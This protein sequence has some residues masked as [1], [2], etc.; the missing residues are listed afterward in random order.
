MLRPTDTVARFGGDEFVILCENFGGVGDA[1]QL[2]ARVVA[3]TAAPWDAQGWFMPVH[4]SIGFAVADSATTE[5]SAL[6]R[7]AD[8]AMYLAKNVPGSM[9]VQA[10]SRRA[11][12]Q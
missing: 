9:S 12:P 1:E 3:V 6:L 4:V 7:D 2:A 8:T 11:E 5:P 10:P